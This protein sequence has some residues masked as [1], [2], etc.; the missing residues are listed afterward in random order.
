METHTLLPGITVRPMDVPEFGKL[1]MERRS[2]MFDRSPSV[3]IGGML[4]PDEIE[5]VRRLQARTGAS[6]RRQ[7]A[8]EA[9]GTVIGWTYGRQQDAEAFT[10]VNT[11]IAPDYRGRGIYTAL[12]SFVIDVARK[13]GFQR[14]R[15]RH[16]ATNNAVLVPKLRAGFLL[17]GMHLDETYGLMADLTYYTNPLRREIMTVRSGECRVSDR[18]RPFLDL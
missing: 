5:A 6:W 8:L 17:T 14:I 18:L 4:E 13:E 16:V 1:F 12:L 2:E 7:W 9:E 3:N 10:M 11:A 15:S